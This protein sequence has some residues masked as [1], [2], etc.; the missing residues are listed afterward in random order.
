MPQMA[1]GRPR[2]RFRLS[3]KRYYPFLLCTIFPRSARKN[4]SKKMIKNRA[5]A[6]KKGARGRQTAQ[7]RNSYLFIL[8]H[9]T[10]AKG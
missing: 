1:A 7:L 4:R 10:S 6:G 5:A 3:S 9:S 8:L 2:Q